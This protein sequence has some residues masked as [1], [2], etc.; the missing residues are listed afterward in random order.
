MS[1]HDPEYR[2]HF[3]ETHGPEAYAREL[4]KHLDASTVATVNGHAIRI[5]HCRFGK[6][7]SVEPTGRAF[8]T[9]DAAKAYAETTP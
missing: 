5:V 2:A 7:Y 6:L 1:F 4:Q 9:L 3:I 8:V